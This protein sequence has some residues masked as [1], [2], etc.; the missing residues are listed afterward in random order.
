MKLKITQK[1][2]FKIALYKEQIRKFFE[3]TDGKNKICKKDF[4]S[5]CVAFLGICLFLYPLMNV[6]NTPTVSFDV[7]TQQVLL[8]NNTYI[9]VCSANSKSSKTELLTPNSV[10]ILQ[11]KVL[12][13]PKN[14]AV[15]PG[16]CQ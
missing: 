11:R 15:K 10:I 7:N 13:S 1:L 12:R 9:N 8:K 16:E 6:W 3:G 14:H 4:F 5:L 2:K